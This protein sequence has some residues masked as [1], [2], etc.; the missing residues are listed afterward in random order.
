MPVKWLAMSLEP[1]A[2]SDR[3]LPAG[4]PVWAAAPELKSVSK[5]RG[6][7]SGGKSSKSVRKVGVRLIRGPFVKPA[8][9]ADH[10]EDEESLFRLIRRIKGPTA[11]DLFC[12]AGGLSLGL[13]DAGF[14]VLM[15]IDSDR[16]AIETHASLFPGLSATWDLSDP[17]IVERVAEIVAKGE[18]T[19]VAGG[20]PCQ[21]FSSAGKA[22]MRH[23]VATGRRH[24]KDDRRELWQSFLAVIEKALPPAVLMENVPEIA[25]DPD[26]GI[27]RAMVDKLEGLGYSV[28][29]RLIETWR[30]GVPQFRERF[31]LVALRGHRP[32]L[33]PGETSERVT[34]DNAIGDLPPVEGGARPE[35][36]ADG[37][38]EY[39]GPETR[40][41]RRAR[42]NVAEGSSHRIHDHITRPVREDDRQVFLQMDS[43]TKYTDIPEQF[44][45][46]RDDIFTD[47][48][49]RLDAN[50]LS[51]TITAH[52][53][54]DGYW[55]IH[56]SQPRTL[57]VR[58]AARIQ[59]FRDDV[60]FAGPPSSAFRQIG[61]AVPPVMA[62]ELGKAILEAIGPQR[63]SER[64]FSTSAVS[65]ELGQWFTELR[66]PRI[67][68][69]RADTR[70]LVILAESLLDRVR[71]ETAARA[72]PLMAGFRTP[73]MTL[74]ARDELLEIAGYVGR[75]QKV[76]EIDEMASYFV[77]DPKALKSAETIG[78]A[79][80]VDSN[81]AALACWVVPG[82][83]PAPVTVGTT[84]LRVTARVTGDG[85]DQRNRSTDGRLA[86][87]RMI[88]LGDE[89]RMAFL[90]LVE[91]G[92]SLCR[93]QSPL[94]HECP[95]LKMC[96]K[97]SAHLR[98]RPV[99]F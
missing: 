98:R 62:E 77:K 21:P 33:W 89:A 54:K 13:R 59:T 18:I 87:A 25:L 24:H 19:L 29:T 37:F 14:E 60:R 2:S 53:S 72:W 95:L 11:I 30:Y 35:G 69:L 36:G 86:V 45:R 63:T 85:V 88:G 7:R 49:K 39:S 91:L 73:R 64:A 31:F 20:P 50:D 71:P 67:P 58:E 4:G 6:M 55:Y 79:P 3:A 44:R 78:N 34:V 28:A 56:P 96:A 5:G 10:C 22:L 15:G 65:N 57:T 42:E 41:Q 94:C 47:K 83:D 74:E 52:I 75:R 84:I 26:I 76:S 8:H 38:W 16:E 80:N 97:G 70:W 12:G 17:E 32:F 48:Y 81:T 61:N 43:R 99:L 90:G 1:L 27:L 46:Y 82:R 92:R 40:F 9:H 23:L 66:S 93:P 51:R 68:W